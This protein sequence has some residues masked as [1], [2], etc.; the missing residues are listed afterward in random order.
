MK[1]ALNRDDFIT[2]VALRANFTKTDIELILETIIA[3]FIDVVKE[4]AILKVRG[5]GKLY[6]QKLP[7]RKGKAG[8]SLPPTTKIIFKLAETIRYAEKRERQLM[9]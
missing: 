7:A 2:E 8:I 6:T 1:R 3:V 5:F 4:N 9:E